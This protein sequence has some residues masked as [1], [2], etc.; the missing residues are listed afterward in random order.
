MRSERA[1]GRRVVL[2]TASD[3]RWRSAVADHLGLFD[4]VMASDGV[5]NLSAQRKAAALV[6][7]LR[8]SAASTTPATR[9]TI[10]ACGRRAARDCRSNAGAAV[11]RAAARVARRSS[12][13]SRRGRPA[14]RVWLRA[15]RLHQW[16]KNL[17]L[18]PAAG[19]RAPVRRVPLLLRGGRRLRGLRPVRVG[20]VPGQRHGRPRKRPRPS[21][22]A[23]SGR[24]PRALSPLH[25][26]AVARRCCSWPAFALAR[27]RRRSVRGLAGG[28]SRA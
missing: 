12:A 13:S 16:V 25:G 19:R 3:E 27:Q 15:M 21:A 20:R 1:R 26:L 5:T 23:A 18:L 10:C 2:C 9:A 8:R 24:S 4:D 7:A 6:R 28:L 11:R 22:Q 17:L 14:S